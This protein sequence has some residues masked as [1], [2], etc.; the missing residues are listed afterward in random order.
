MSF[1]DNFL[2]TPSGPAREALVYNAAIAQGPPKNMVPITVNASNGVKITY[3]AMPN[4]LIIDG[5]L[6]SMAPSTA[7]ALAAAW[8]LNLPTSTISR[9][10]YNAADTKLRAPP[11]SGSGYVGKDGKKYS[12]KDVV[13][14][15]IGASDAAVFYSDLTNKELAKYK[16]NTG[17]VPTLIA[18][19][20]KDILEPISNPN[21]VS[22]G[23]WQGNDAK[24]LQPY[25]SPHKGEAT[26]HTEYALYTRLI[27]NDVII[28]MP[29]GKKVKTTM[30]KLKLNPTLS[31]AVTSS[32]GVKKYPAAPIKKIDKPQDIKQPEK[33]QLSKKYQPEKPQSGSLSLL[34][35]IDKF[36]S[37][38]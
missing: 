34:D 28:T 12:G 8:H 1:R 37:Q 24:P 30:D 31:Q 27:G 29:D 38:I 9:Q 2:N 19:H 11:L 10:I 5:I 4:Y 21:D 15:R 14:D 7:Q 23:G 22:M 33:Q 18:G 36:L 26:R 3:F 6:A 13:K 35:R 17:K 32:P 20:G 16:E 25:G